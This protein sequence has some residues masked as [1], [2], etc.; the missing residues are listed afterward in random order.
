MHIETRAL[1]FVAA[2]ATCWWFIVASAAAAFQQSANAPAPVA[3]AVAQ[4]AGAAT[5][6]VSG[7]ATSSGSGAAK[8]GTVVPKAQGS[9]AGNVSTAHSAPRSVNC[10]ALETHASALPAVTIVVFNQRD[11]D[12][13]QRLSDLLKANDGATV[14]LRTSDG[15]WHKGTVARLKSCFGRG[16]LFLSGDTD[17]LKSHDDF[18]LRFPPKAVS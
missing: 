3:R 6:K 5:G 10:R 14:E 13:H 2:I 15:K 18:L 1:G 8:N 9:A 4:S 7:Q 16:L 12:D 11:R 17:L